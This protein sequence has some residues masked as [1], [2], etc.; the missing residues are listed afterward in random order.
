MLA[1]VFVL[2]SAAQ[3]QVTADSLVAES[4]V[5]ANLA[6]NIVSTNETTGVEVSVYY[7]TFN[8]MLFNHET[9]VL[10]GTSYSTRPAFSWRSITLYKNGVEY[11]FSD[12]D[13]SVFDPIT[14][15]SVPSSG[16]VTAGVPADTFMLSTNNAIVLP[17]TVQFIVSSTTLDAFGLKLNEIA[18][19]AN[20][21]DFVTAVTGEYVTAG[22]VPSSIPEPWACA[23]IFGV[24][25]L[26]FAAWRRF[27]ASQTAV[28]CPS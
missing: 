9:D 2:A 11:P 7:A 20:N 28:S 14:L 24:I 21:I 23:A 15:Y 22:S 19:T 4:F 27:T 12:Y 5:P 25:V 8:I 1:S 16:V 26:G 10:F 17:V 3:A 13:T 18:W 6:R